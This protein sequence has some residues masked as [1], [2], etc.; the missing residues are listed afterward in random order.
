[1]AEEKTTRTPEE[2]RLAALDEDIA[3]RKERLDAY[4]T[5]TQ[6]KIDELAKR[7]EALAQTVEIQHLRAEASQAE[8]YLRLL[9][10]HGIEVPGDEPAGAGEGVATG[11]VA[12]EPE[13]E[14]A[15]ATAE[16]E[17]ATAPE[18][19]GA[20]ATPDDDFGGFGF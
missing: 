14:P 16:P 17:P 18:A 10:E 4:V 9:R 13:A 12:P 19:P 8:V 5:K 2:E 3:R 20:D 11:D 15:E 1:M 7:R 6:A